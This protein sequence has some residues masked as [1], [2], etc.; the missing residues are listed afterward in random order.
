MRSGEGEEEW[1]GD[2]EW[3]GGGGVGKWRRSEQREEE[4]RRREGVSRGRIS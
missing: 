4:W 2:E 1:V 3:E